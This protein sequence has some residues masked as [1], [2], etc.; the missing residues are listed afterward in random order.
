[1]WG[2]R[3][4]THRDVRAPGRAGSRSDGI[5]A[6]WGQILI[7]LCHQPQALGR[8]KDQRGGQAWAL[9]TRQV[10]ETDLVLSLLDWAGQEVPGPAGG[11]FL[12]LGHLCLR[13]A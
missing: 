3:Q 4:H 1:M 5:F 7:S 2:G 10:W 12:N 8:N 13:L 11:L 6:H 9:L